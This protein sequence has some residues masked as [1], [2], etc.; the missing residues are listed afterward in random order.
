[1]ITQ[2]AVERISGNQQTR[3]EL[4]ILEV[5]AKSFLQHGFEGTSINA[6]ARAAGISKES[7]YR[8]FDSKKDLFEAVIAK[9]LAD[10]QDNLQFLD[11][12]LSGQDLEQALVST[13]ETILSVVNSDHTL[14]LR[15]LIFQQVSTYPDIGEYYYKIGPGEAY[16]HLRKV[17]SL[18]QDRTDFDP[19]QLARYFV[20]MVLHNTLLRRQ[21][22]MLAKLD[23]GDIRR[24]SETATRDFLNAFFRE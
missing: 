16:E 24:A 21:C 3:K 19:E 1:M 8:Y 11:V 10:Y 4:E 7:I 13:A 23:P 6:M 22:G 2:E 12:E 17:F 18:H 14:S 20:G 15:R 5:A 9:E